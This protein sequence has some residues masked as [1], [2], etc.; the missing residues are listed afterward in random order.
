MTSNR[1]ERWLSSGTHHGSGGDIE[2]VRVAETEIWLCD[3]VLPGVEKK[4]RKTEQWVVVHQ[5]RPVLYTQVLQ[6]APDGLPCVPVLW[7]TMFSVMPEVRPIATRAH[8]EFA[9][10]EVNKSVVDL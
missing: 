8:A 4:E 1:A 2:V 7:A 5:T 3:N 9:V 10:V 6:E